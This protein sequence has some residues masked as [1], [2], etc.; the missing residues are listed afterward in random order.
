MRAVCG[1]GGG[2]G[3]TWIE[4]WGITGGG[5]GVGGWVAGWNSLPNAFRLSWN[6]AS[7]TADLELVLEL[8]KL[9]FEFDL[10]RL[11]LVGLEFVVEDDDDNPG[12]YWV[13]PAFFF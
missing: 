7:P 2:A 6:D 13:L 5:D 3:F 4:G 11:L 9:E 12:A 10:V 8:F 1:G